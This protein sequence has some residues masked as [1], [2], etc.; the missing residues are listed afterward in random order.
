MFVVPVVGCRLCVLMMAKIDGGPW[1]AKR[2]S[3]FDSG[4]RFN[5]V[6]GRGFGFLS[7][8]V[9]FACLRAADD[10]FDSP[11]TT[12]KYKRARTMAGSFVFGCGDRI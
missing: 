4:G 2:P 12:A 10:R 6:A 9:G 1:N 8:G 5:L 7:C 11:A 3:G